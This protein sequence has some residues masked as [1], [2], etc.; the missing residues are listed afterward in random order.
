MLSL[1]LNS[2]KTSLSIINIIDFYGAIENKRIMYQNILCQTIIIVFC[3]YICVTSQTRCS[4]LQRQNLH[5]GCYD[6]DVPSISDDPLCVDSDYMENTSLSHSILNSAAGIV[7]LTLDLG[8]KC[9][10][11]KYEITIKTSDKDWN[12]KSCEDGD[13][14]DQKKI[15]SNVF[16]EKESNR[17]LTKCG[18]VFY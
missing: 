17:N 7:E 9:P 5:F 15:H 10:F 18:Q 11:I 16:Y 8:R 4:T 6:D 12:S 2:D 1:Y 3:S 14:D 13:H